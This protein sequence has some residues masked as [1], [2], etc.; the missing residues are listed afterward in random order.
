[1]AT[2]PTYAI[3]VTLIDLEGEESTVTAYI[4]ATGIATDI[5]DDILAFGSTLA[6]EIAAV[7]NAKIKSWGFTAEHINDL[8]LPAADGTAW[9]QNIE[10]KLFLEL[11]SATTG[12]RFAISIPAPKNADFGTDQETVS[13]TAASAIDTL[14][15]DLE[16]NFVTVSN[17]TAMKRIK[18]YL[19]RSKTRR[20]LRAG[21][22]SEQGG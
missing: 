7:S 6:T 18:G 11:I 19:R 22:P 1:M 10:D 5:V 20:R 9:Y 14:L 3:H 16:T 2:K 8:T 13:W 17:G 15:V 4:P 21:I 12:Q